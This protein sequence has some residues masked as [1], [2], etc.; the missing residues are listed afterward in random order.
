[1]N[2]GCNVIQLDPNKQLIK[3][4]ILNKNMKII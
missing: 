2:N 1:M 3:H 4:D